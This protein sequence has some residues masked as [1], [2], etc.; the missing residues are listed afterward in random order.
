MEL[1]RPHVT[2]HAVRN[3][4]CHAR[5][6]ALAILLVSVAAAATACTASDPEPTA[7]PASPTETSSSPAAPPG[8]RWPDLPETLLPADVANRLEAEMTSWVD[9]QMLPGVTAAVASPQGVWVGAA[10]VDG[11]GAPL[12]PDVGMA[13]LDI[14]WSFT[15]AEAMLL[16]ERGELDLDAPAS[17]YVPVPQ[18]ANG[19]TVRQLLEHRAGIP[20]PGSEV[21]E[22]PLNSQPDA[23]WTTERF[24]EPVAKA[25][26][27]PDQRTYV[28]TTNYELL[29]LV[30]EKVSGQRL[31]A[32]YESDLWSPLGLSRLAL[33]DEQRLPP[34]L[35]ARGEDGDLPDGIDDARYL[36][37][38]AFVSAVRASLGA[39]GDAG[40]AARWGYLLYGGHL[41]TPESVAEMTDFEEDDVGLGSFNCTTKVL[42][43]P[44]IDCV[45]QWGTRL[46]YSAVLTVVPTAQI[47]VVVLT[48]S[49]AAAYGFVKWLISAGDLL[50]NAPTA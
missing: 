19:V 17:T 36:P 5:T 27:P 43:S 13:L 23:H 45:G 41:L 18:V 2:V 24:L 38:R 46:G 3:A 50:G 34:P 14:T 6:R 25:T 29:G 39:A 7:A 49:T 48:P 47:S 9:R 28:D 12:T 31:G 44:S 30:V 33:Q 4:R 16:A 10:G 22:E 32:T 26:D 20:D 8:Q 40:T 1:S 37:F 11:A 21:Y 42:E 15:A 35:A